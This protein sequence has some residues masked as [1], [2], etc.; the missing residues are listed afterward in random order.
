MHIIG[1]S[2][3]V[4]FVISAGI[5]IIGIAEVIIIASLL[6]SFFRSAVILIKLGFIIRFPDTF[7]LAHNEIGVS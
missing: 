7:V 3:I 5:I 1:V 4:G 2:F 6:W